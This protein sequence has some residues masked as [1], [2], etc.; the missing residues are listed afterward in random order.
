MATLVPVMLFQTGMIDQLPDPPGSIFDSE[1]IT[2][3]RG[4]HPLGIPDAVLG[5]GSY[6]ATFALLLLA[7]RHPA[8]RTLL[9]AKLILDGS[10]AGIN[11]VRQVVT[12]GKICSWC[13][14]TA[15]A[16]ACMVWSGRRVI[17][18]V[19]QA[20]KADLKQRVSSVDARAGE[21]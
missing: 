7:R 9:G 3:S 1:K 10:M 14:G 18:D 20:E 6:A 17:A 5:L 4:A 12:F 16:T 21:V 19:L 8:A 15:I 2:T 13:T 11:G